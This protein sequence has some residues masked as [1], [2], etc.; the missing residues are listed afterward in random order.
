MSAICCRSCTWLNDVRGHDRLR[1]SCPAP[2][3]VDGRRK[4][5]GPGSGLPVADFDA[6]IH[7]VPGDLGVDVDI[8]DEPFG[9]WPGDAAHYSD[10]SPEPQGC[11]TGAR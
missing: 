11:A 2:R 10:T 8:R 1:R 3:T 7:E 6:R 4:S 9:F 5:F